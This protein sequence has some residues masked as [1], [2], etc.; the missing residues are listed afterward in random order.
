MTRW[1]EPWSEADVDRWL[2]K[3]GK[4]V[5]RDRPKGKIVKHKPSAMSEAQFLKAVL[6]LAKL[7]GW[8]TAHFR[9]AQ[10]KR[11]NWVTAVQG[12]GK[13]FPD[14]V[15]VRLRGGLIFAELKRDSSSKTTP[16]QD[17]WIKDLTDIEYQSSFVV[18]VYVWRPSDMPKIIEI[19]R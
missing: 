7:N 2:S 4:Q 19:L 6:S 14:L 3:I 1:G 12:D 8:R 9:P 15:M 18:R 5:E 10:T 17:V 11:G 16:D 13:G